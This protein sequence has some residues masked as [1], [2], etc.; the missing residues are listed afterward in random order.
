MYISV[1]I[2][3]Q[4]LVQSRARAKLDHGAQRSTLRSME[5]A[6]HRVHESRHGAHPGRGQHRQ[7]GVRWVDPTQRNTR[8]CNPCGDEV[9]WIAIDEDGVVRPG[10]E[11]RH[12]RGG[13]A[14]PG[15]DAF[16]SKKRAR[17][18]LL[19]EAPPHDPGELQLVLD[20]EQLQEV[21]C[22]YR[23]G[24]CNCRQPLLYLLLAHHAPNNADQG[25]DA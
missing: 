18:V 23:S 3:G 11:L 25:E 5:D 6:L 15:Q 7:R 12:E 16:A 8:H 19:R 17:G 21:S 1:A 2:S 10:G 22:Q 20:P 13:L 24:T 4:A 14:V 9:A